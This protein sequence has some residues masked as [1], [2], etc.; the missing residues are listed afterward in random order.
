M[1]HQALKKVASDLRV[2]GRAEDGIIEAVEG[3]NEQY[4]IGVQSHPEAVA[5]IDPRWQAVYTDFVTAAERY[6]RRSAKTK[7]SV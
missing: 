4:M 1:H 2:I 3:R 6:A 7:A 5:A